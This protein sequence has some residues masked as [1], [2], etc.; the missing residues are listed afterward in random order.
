MAGK[1]KAAAAADAPV[2]VDEHG[3]DAAAVAVDVAV[4]VV[5]LESV[6]ADPSQHQVAMPSLLADGTPEHPDA[7]VLVEGDD[8]RAVHF[9]G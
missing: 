8:P 9:A 6:A 1:E 3:D 5:E 7:V 4:D 2:V